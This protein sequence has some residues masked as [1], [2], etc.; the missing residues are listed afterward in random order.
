MATEPATAAEILD[1]EPREP[2][3][4]A[5]TLAPA[6]VDVKW[7]GI[8]SESCEHLKRYHFG[9]L[10]CTAFDEELHPSFE[11]EPV[12]EKPRAERCI[13]CLVAEDLFGTR[14]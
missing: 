12:T 13:N 11:A 1:D 7:S 8:C 4:Y 6:T 9:A 2:V 5:I 10:R 3:A 14:S